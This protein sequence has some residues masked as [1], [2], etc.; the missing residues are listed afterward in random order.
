MEEEEEGGGLKK[1][2]GVKK[3]DSKKVNAW[4]TLKIIATGSKMV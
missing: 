3:K 4:R 1:V 2:E